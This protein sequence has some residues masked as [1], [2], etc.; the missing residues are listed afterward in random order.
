MMT[1]GGT[2]VDTSREN[3]KKWYIEGQR[4]RAKDLESGKGGQVERMSDGSR[5][6]GAEE[7]KIGAVGRREREK[8]EGGD[9]RMIWLGRWRE[10]WRYWRAR[11]FFCG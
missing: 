7:E 8:R 10:E 6:E 2:Q 9:G 5:S 4:R 11:V 3:D 1:N